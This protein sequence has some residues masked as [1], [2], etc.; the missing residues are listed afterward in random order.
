MSADRVY[1][2]FVIGGGINGCGIAR[3]AV[4]RGYSVGLCE[5]NDLAS[6]TSSGSTKLIHG[7]L[8]YLEHYEFRLVRE[9]L[10]E[11]ERLWA[12]APHIIWPLRFVLPH[13]SGLRPAWFLRL[14]LFL[15]DH[16]GGRKRLPPTKA[17]D[18]RRD[19]AGEPLKPEFTTGFEYSDCWVQD[20]RLTVLNARDAADRGADIMTRTECTG[21]RRDDGLWHIDLKDVANGT[22]QTVTAK[23]VINAGGP[24][25]DHILNRS[26]GDNGA[27]NVRLVQGSHIVT[28]K[29]YDHDRCYIFQNADKRIFFA[30]PYEQDFTLIGTTD[31]D[32]DGDLDHFGISDEEVD[33]LI[34]GAN[35]YF[36]RR[37]TRDDIVW[38]YS[39]VRP[40]Y[41]DGAGAA[42][43]ATR[44]Y[45]LRADEVPGGPPLIN[46]FGGKIT[47]YR[48]LAESMMEKVETFLGRKG[49]VWTE[50][51]ALPGGDFR[52]ADIDEI[53]KSYVA[54]QP[55][56]GDRTIDRLI[57]HYGTAAAVILDRP[58][59]LGHCFGADLF[60]AEVRYLMEKEW[61]RTAEDVLWRRTKMGLR[62]TKD[63]AGNL[64]RWMQ[65]N[66]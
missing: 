36:D 21:L 57:R 47:T 62:L 40:L 31:R 18:L 52:V 49:P 63:E 2:I 48:R 30:I 16:L 25:V 28:R 44:D 14:G 12:N 10:M 23:L 1:D 20:A 59:G 11:R 38:T 5:K 9:S 39:G 53:R 26:L 4:G 35:G 32:F 58:D 42:Q 7:G 27:H 13:H 66:G 55:S 54:K 15:Y 51:A 61:A 6:G 50:S 17:L 8:R 65:D 3:D 33:Y 37:I 41:D 60:E 29:L 46:I 56:L 64:D 19:A 34:A 24:W 22:E 43:E 45:V